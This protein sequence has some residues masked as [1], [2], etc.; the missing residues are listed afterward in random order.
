[1]DAYNNFEPF[2]KYELTFPP[3]K[4]SF[5]QPQEAHFLEEF[6][7]KKKEA[8]RRKYSYIFCWISF[9]YQFGLSYL[10]ILGAWKRD[11]LNLYAYEITFFKKVSQYPIFKKDKTFS[12]WEILL[13][14]N[15][16]VAKV[17]GI[18]KTG[19]GQKFASQ[20]FIYLLMHYKD[21][22]KTYLAFW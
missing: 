21:L 18:E 1:M 12:I 3:N 16:R 8:N 22:T 2:L 17:S 13:K 6:F 9:N 15:L 11:I 19:G 5:Y 10:Y 7:F 20:N 14:I 4:H